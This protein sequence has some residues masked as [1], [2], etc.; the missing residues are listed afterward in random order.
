MSDCLIVLLPWPTAVSSKCLF[1][2]HLFTHTH[3][4]THICLLVIYFSYPLDLSAYL[5]NLPLTWMDTH[6]Q[7]HTRTLALTT[8]GLTSLYIPHMDLWREDKN[9]FK[10]FDVDSVSGIKPLII[11]IPLLQRLPSVTPP[12]Q[13]KIMCFP[14][15][16]LS[17]YPYL[18]ISV[19][20]IYNQLKNHYR[21]NSKTLVCAWV[22]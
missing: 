1:C 6:R 3:T 18:P 13:V 22:L 16:S 12:P 14:C 15:L 19:F 21:M 8:Y 7:T 2:W 17:K 10:T 4:H 5:F 20:S 9:I 11:S